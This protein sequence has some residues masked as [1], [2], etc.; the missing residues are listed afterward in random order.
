ML[1]LSLWFHPI[2][3]RNIPFTFKLGN[4]EVIRGWDIGLS[5]MCIGEIRKLTI[6]S[7]LA[8]ANE[9]APPKIYPGA[10]LVFEIQLIDIL[11][12]EK[13]DGLSSGVS[14]FDHYDIDAYWNDE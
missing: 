5:N 13:D 14:L 12:G 6:P 4:S 11:N 9:G 2:I 1:K 8:Y 10:T 3:N 7:D